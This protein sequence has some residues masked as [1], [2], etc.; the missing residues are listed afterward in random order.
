MPLRRGK[1]QGQERTDLTKCSSTAKMCDQTPASVGD[2]VPYRRSC[3]TTIPSQNPKMERRPVC[4]GRD[5][6]C[7]DGMEAYR[8]RFV[9]LCVQLRRV[10]LQILAICTNSVQVRPRDSSTTEDEP[11]QGMESQG[12]SQHPE[13]VQRRRRLVRMRSCALLFTTVRNLATQ[14]QSK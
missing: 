1:T 9:Q 2:A 8:V 6:G 5:G 3:Q 10:L 13:D 11:S 14:Q 12:Q 7:E 4:S